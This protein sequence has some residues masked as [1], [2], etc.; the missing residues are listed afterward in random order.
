MM[1]DDQKKLISGVAA[2]AISAGLLILAAAAVA[3]GVWT[4]WRWAF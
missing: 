3:A 1:T 2:F 4:I